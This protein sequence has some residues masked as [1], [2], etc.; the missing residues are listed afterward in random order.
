ME[1]T[2]SVNDL[3]RRVASG[4]TSLEDG[5]AELRGDWFRTK[6]FIAFSTAAAANNGPDD[7]RALCTGYQA[8]SGTID[9]EWVRQQQERDDTE[10]WARMRGNASVYEGSRG[11]TGEAWED[12]RG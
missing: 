10:F 7:Y 9:R 1:T 11:S 12:E 5:A 3:C 2:W 6:A 8:L 4:A